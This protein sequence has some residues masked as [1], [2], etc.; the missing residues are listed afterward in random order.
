M[1]ILLFGVLAE[2]VGKTEI[3]KKSV[4]LIS[5]K[6]D[7]LHEFPALDRYRYQVA[8]NHERTTGNVL[9]TDDDEIALL[10]PFAGG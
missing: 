8:V 1:K 4:D 5:L 3:E 9:L 7:L 2:V 6:K 10:P